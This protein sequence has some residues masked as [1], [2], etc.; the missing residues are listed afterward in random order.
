MADFITRLITNN[1]LHHLSAII[2]AY[3]NLT[4]EDQGAT[5]IVVYSTV[6]LTAKQTKRLEEIL[7]KSYGPDLRIRYRIKPEIIGGVVVRS[8]SHVV[9]ASLTSQFQQLATD[10][11]GA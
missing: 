3:S 6:K 7:S 9:D 10:M 4:L 2:R 8:R 1:R 11:K 5:P